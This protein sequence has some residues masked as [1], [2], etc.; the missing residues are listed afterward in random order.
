MG[1]F[2][3]NSNTINDFLNNEENIKYESYKFIENKKGKILNSIC[4]Y[5]VNSKDELNELFDKI[6]DNNYCEY[7]MIRKI[8]QIYTDDSL[9]KLTENQIESINN[10]LGKII[11]FL[12][13]KL[14]QIIKS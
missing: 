5:F 7:F 2:L 12:P 13:E 6:V 3:I 11:K 14:H 1:M 9:D 4:L 8:I 10:F